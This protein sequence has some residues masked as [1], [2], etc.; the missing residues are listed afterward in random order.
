[1]ISRLLT[2]S[3]V[4]FALTGAY[5]V[6]AWWMR[7]QFP[8]RLQQAATVVTDPIP[9]DLTPA[10]NL[11]V[12]AT[13][14]PD[15]TWAHGARYQIRTEN[16]FLFADAWQPRGSQGQIECRP[17][18]GVWVW[19]KP[20]SGVEQALAMVCD[21]ATIEFVN[22]FETKKAP[23]P[24]RIVRGTLQGPVRIVG[25]DGLRLSGRS[26]RFSEQ[27]LL[28][29][30]DH[31]VE[32]DYGPH[33]GSANSFSMTLSAFSGP[34][35]KD[36]PAVQGVRLLQLNKN[37]KTR[38][39]LTSG[40]EKTPF[41]VNC[42][43]AFEFD[44]QQH[45]A[46]YDNDVLAY[47]R[48]PS[49]EGGEQHFE[50]LTCDR[51][52]VQF[53]PRERAAA[54]T[55][56]ASESTGRG[57]QGDSVSSNQANDSPSIIDSDSRESADPGG[58]SNARR[59]R[60]N[61]F[62]RVETDLEFQSFHAT[63]RS[64]RVLSTTRKLQGEMQSLQYD[65]VR[66]QLVLKSD[67][68]VTL[69]R[70]LTR[71]RV[72]QIVVQLTAAGQ[73]AWITCLGIGSIESR[74][75]ETNEVL[76][77]IDWEKR[78]S[79]APDSPT[80]TGDGSTD[81]VIELEGAASFRQPGERMALAA[82]LIR[83][84]I[85]HLATSG[86]RDVL[87]DDSSVANDP[88]VANLTA[89]AAQTAEPGPRSGGVDMPLADMP[90]TDYAAGVQAN[91][92]R[93]QAAD[94]TSGNRSAADPQI[95]P[96]RLLANDNVVLVSPQLEAETGRLEVWFEPT[97]G[98][99]GSG[100]LADGQR[101]SA[102]SPGQ[103]SANQPGGLQL[104]SGQTP[105]RA[106]S[107][108]MQP[109]DVKSDLI[110]VKLLDGGP[111]QSP[112]LAEVW[113]EGRVIVKQLRRTRPQ[114]TDA[115]YLQVFGDRLHLVNRGL[116]AETVHV[117]GQPALI[118]DPMI[119]V[120]GASLHLDRAEN[121]IWV[122]GS[123]M[124]QLPVER[125]PD[126][127]VL[128]QPQPLDVEWKESMSF[129]G[130]RADFQGQVVTRLPLALTSALAGGDA[131]APTTRSEPEPGGAEAGENRLHCQHMVVA[132]AQPISLRQIE[133]QS[134]SAPP[135]LAT[136]SCQEN[137]DLESTV[138]RG[139]KVFEVRRAHVHEFDVNQK[140]GEVHAQGP[141]WIEVWRRD[142]T[143]QVVVPVRENSQANR[144]S[145]V[146]ASPWGYTRIDF[147]SHLTGH[148]TQRVT[149]FH[150]RVRIV[151]GPVKHATGVI[152]A[153]NLPE[154]AG[155][156]KSQSLRLNAQPAAAGQA[157]GFMEMVA[158]GNAELEGR[159]KGQSFHSQADQ[160]TY[161]ESKTLYVIRAHGLAKARISRQERPGSPVTGGHG[162][163]IEF[164]PTTGYFSID[165][166][167]SGEAP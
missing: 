51:L 139:G 31:P 39:E 7:P 18:A 57:S 156:M 160:I 95:R 108:D 161:D 29:W 20:G 100:D 73:L 91:A 13:Y 102:L 54:D 119:Q 128:S 5:T 30:S 130:Q 33:R 114:P 98:A 38:L 21:A 137:V 165:G 133:R 77:A 76:Y 103:R 150:E 46:R 8:A 9:E 88:E 123:G 89:V 129:D 152:D 56:M 66:R 32:F 69:S 163:R 17:F 127:R 93:S 97:R 44:L 58:S 83:I 70:E 43:G 22:P 68:T 16:M 124:L 111:D 109:L 107:V 118:R 90:E 6:Y 47:R 64:V 135:E 81:D 25:P 75:P 80:L 82:D 78:L 84:W 115:D 62:E 67:Q 55:T 132:L 154:R 92:A 110:R 50:Q 71:L 61:R 45:Q 141:G 19:T 94:S 42:A 11:R 104:V 40:R 143:Q 49:V 99:G 96:K 125:L 112:R 101:G 146:D 116:G 24:G 23:N 142:R 37:V 121:L 144:P 15:S 34:L 145:Q 159:Q 52:A 106:T 26:F 28:V 131:E 136:I 72:P 87:S 166:F 36:L 120:E 86:L 85:D 113:T 105:G 138:F 147:A 149:E 140:T 65:A 167:V 164:N 63:G 59:P 153:N 162:Q 157:R 35:E 155:W 60:A 2:T 151:Y 122:E 41:D 27:S 3:V 134:S 48:L 79:Q 1:M 12:A 14:L 53:Q 117:T 74:D 158:K 4:V 126:G 148:L 10:E